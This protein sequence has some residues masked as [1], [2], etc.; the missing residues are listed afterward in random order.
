MGRIKKE[1]DSQNNDDEQ[2]QVR[3]DKWLWVARFYK[4]RNIA[5]TAIEAGKVFVDGAR[6]KPGKI[7]DVGQIISISLPSGQITVIVMALSKVRRSASYA[8]DMYTETAESMTAREA[9]KSIKNHL[10]SRPPEKR[11]FGE[12]RRALRRLKE[13]DN[14]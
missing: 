3:L 6:A 13:G 10:Q 9:T 12:A 4:T 5:H 2:V 7:V 14:S 1:T 8:Q 11:P